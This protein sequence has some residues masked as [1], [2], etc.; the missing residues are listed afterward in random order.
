[1][2][3][4]IWFLILVLAPVLWAGITLDILIN[5]SHPLQHKRGKRFPLYIWSA[6]LDELKHDAEVEETLKKLDE[7]GLMV[8]HK[9]SQ[10]NLKRRLE[11]LIQIGRIQTRLGIPVSINAT[12]LSYR[13]FNG[14]SETAHR[15]SN[16]KPFF[17]RSFSKKVKM[18]C[19]FTLKTQYAR[20]IGK[21]LPFLKAYKA[22]G[23]TPD[24]IAIDWEVDGPHEWN[25]AWENSKKCIRCQRL[26]RNIEEFRYFQKAIRNLR[27]QAQKEVFSAPIREF[28]PSVKIGNY[29][30]YPDQGFRYW[31]DYFE[32]REAGETYRPWVHNFPQSGY[33]VAMPVVYTWHWIYKLYDFK[34]PQYRWFYNMLKVGSNAG[35]S[36]PSATPIISFLHWTTLNPE[37]LPQKYTPLNEKNYKEL[38][39]HLLLRG[40][41]AFCLWTPLGDLRKELIPLHQVYQESMEFS[42]FIL[43]GKP[44]WF[45]VPTEGPVISGILYQNQLLVRRTDFG[46]MEG[47]VQKKVKGHRISI[48]PLNQ[49]N[50]IIL[51]DFQ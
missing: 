6:D 12:P 32:W 11:K 1:M 46:E 19:P 2:K 8:F 39:W 16:H 22:A 40:H 50:Q 34:N 18:G 10:R 41:D 48:P 51:L 43:D 47:S 9:W 20:M 3:T 26:I 33:T 5:N 42:P 15:D 24:F 38:L 17:D 35:K 44:L 49:K 4:L 27:A 14:N 31:W 23:I 37:K 28:F 25:N 13:F 7:R 21:W 30:E 36:T 29:G 45:D